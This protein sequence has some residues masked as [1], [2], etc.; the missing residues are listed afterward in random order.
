M[1]T[2]Q[3]A[4]NYDIPVEKIAEPAYRTADRDGTRRGKGRGM[5]SV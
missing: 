5:N 1:R 2:Y 4:G 3:G